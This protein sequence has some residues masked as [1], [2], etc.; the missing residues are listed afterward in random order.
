[1]L[2]VGVHCAAST[3]SS[4]LTL[5]KPGSTKINVYFHPSVYNNICRLKYEKNC[6]TVKFENCSYCKSNA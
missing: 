3:L 6:A 4:F 2:T 1:M 5:K